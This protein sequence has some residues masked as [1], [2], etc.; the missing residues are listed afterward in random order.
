MA[1]I[2]DRQFGAPAPDRY[3]GM[4]YTSQQ[5]SDLRCIE[6][7]TTRYTYGLDRLDRDTMRSAYW[8]DAVDHHGPAFD[9]L[10][11]DYVDVAMA[12]HKRWA[13]SLHTLM[14]QIIELD[15]DGV[16][17]R[18]EA[19]CI[20]Y[21]FDT[22]QP[23]LFQWFGRYLDHFQKRDDEWRILERVCVHEAGR[24][25]DPVVPMPFP[26]EL[27]RPGTFDRPASGRRI[28]P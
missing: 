10:A 5:L 8:P 19:Y 18:G 16:N 22:E 25:D 3:W 21:L 20:A 9:G 23:V 4:A 15:D 2:R 12:S 17:A 27:F 7:V 28:G 11:W 24:V 14:N 13:P 1:C 26:T 6:E